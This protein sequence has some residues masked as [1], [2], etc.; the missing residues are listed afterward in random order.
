[1]TS[2]NFSKN[3]TNSMEAWVGV[4]DEFWKSF[5]FYVS[6]MILLESII[7]DPIDFCIDS[8][9]LISIS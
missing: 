1:M 4:S 9:I 6:V 7:K 3:L 5:E 8:C 2:I